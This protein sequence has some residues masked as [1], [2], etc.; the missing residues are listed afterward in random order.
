MTVF[1]NNDDMEK[2]RIH[3]HM[4]SYTKLQSHANDKTHPP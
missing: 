3:H 4:N 1:S 2:T